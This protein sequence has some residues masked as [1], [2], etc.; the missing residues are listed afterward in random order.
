MRL[1]R[2]VAKDVGA[3]VVE[4]RL[5]ILAVARRGNVA[6]PR[7]APLRESAE[8]ALLAQRREVLSD[9]VGDTMAEAAHRVVVEI[10]RGAMVVMQHGRVSEW[11]GGGPGR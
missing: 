2:G 9:D 7:I 11:L 4:Q 5:E 8:R 10:E 6:S 3:E 1:P